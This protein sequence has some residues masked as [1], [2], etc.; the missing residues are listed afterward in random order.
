M[1]IYDYVAKCPLLQ[2]A[3]GYYDVASSRFVDLI[4]QS[5]HTKLFSKCRGQ[6]I[7]EVQRELHINDHD[8]ECCLWFRTGQLLTFPA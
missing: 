7:E 1:G 2:Y 4:C 5:T 8:S 3:R 6:L